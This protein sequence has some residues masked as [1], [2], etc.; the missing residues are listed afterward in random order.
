[1][2]PLYNHMF[3]N[4][5]CV[6]LVPLSSYQM[7]SHEILA[8]LVIIR[9]ALT[10]RHFNLCVVRRLHLALYTYGCIFIMTKCL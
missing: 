4:Y 8:W 1:M 2:L 7:Q 3:L 5:L 10:T 6:E 9:C